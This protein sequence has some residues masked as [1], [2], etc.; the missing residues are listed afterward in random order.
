[1]TQILKQST[2][3]DVLIGPFVDST[4][5][6]TAE[7]G[8]SPSV[9]LSKNG[10]ALAA[11]N[12]ATTPV[13]DADGYYNCELDATDTN[14]VGTLVLSVVGSA[15]SL[16]VR[17]EYQVIEEAIYDGFYAASAARIPAD[18]TA[19]SGDTAAADNLE[20][21]YDGTGYTNSTAPA[22]RAQVDGISASSG[23]ALNYE[24][25]GDNTGGAIKGVSFVGVQ[26]GTYT[27]TEAEDGTYH[28]ID[29]TANDIDII[30]DFD[31]GGSRTAV[32]FTFKG[33]LVGANDAMVIQAYDFVGADWE[34]RVSLPG[35][36][37]TD[38]ITLSVPLLGKHTGT[39]AD[40]GKVY[41]RFE[42]DGVMSNPTLNVDEL[43]VSAVSNQVSVGYEGGAVWLDTN[44]GTAGT[45]P[46]VNGTADNPSLTLADARTIAD[47][48]NLKIIHALPGSALTLTAADWDQF[49]II[50]HGF[51]LDLNSRS[52]DG[53][54]VK[55]GKI[56]G[57][58][59]ATTTRP[60]FVDCEIN[61]AT[62]PP[63]VFKQCGFTATMTAAIDAGDYI[64]DRCYS[65]VAGTGSPTL[66]FSPV[67]A[68]TTINNRSWKG[69]ATY[70]LD[71]NCK[72]SHEVL[73]GGGTTITT[74]GATEVE[75]R[76]V[77]RSLTVTM[78][79]A[80]A[81]QFVGVTGP[82]TLNGTTTATVNIYGVTGIV[83][84]NT[85]AATVT[86][87]SNGRELLD[88]ARGE[89]SGVPAVN[90]TPLTKLDYL[91][92]AL[93]NELRITATKKTFY[94]DGGS[95]EWEKDLT[96]DGTTYTESEGNAI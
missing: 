2:A 96:D 43:L 8:V 4:D 57:T 32:E 38:N 70:T 25:G 34:T 60:T 40:L 54:L 42:A 76:G 5:G 86:Q 69:G 1:M 24:A 46:D 80:E 30:Y 19:I 79:A 35:Q 37:G 77:T 14:T 36:A 3:V 72:L 63:A 88:G 67:N 64:F 92:M 51:T 71:S 65:A 41:I 47:N 74:G 13:H 81:V 48:K 53:L 50:G 12:D 7:S 82:I 91:F 28:Q 27:N 62:I 45:E 11:K 95:A 20:L 23:G 58:G 9:K 61:T 78:S 68:A 16:P 18:T 21:M 89:A 33:Y 90:E 73:A 39:G 66:D 87:D 83:T 22:S 31:I 17:H 85:T 15:T 44:N 29:D 84:D 6:Y 26:T 59:E 10:Q 56:S 49:E 94:D 75:V 52:I 55:N 93:R